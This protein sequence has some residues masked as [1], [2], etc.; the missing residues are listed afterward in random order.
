MIAI[1]SR[2]GKPVENPGVAWVPYLNAHSCVFCVVQSRYA[3]SCL[4]LAMAH[5]TEAGLLSKQTS[6]MKTCSVADGNLQA[7]N[8]QGSE[9]SYDYIYASC[10]TAHSACLYKSL[11]HKG[12]DLV[13]WTSRKLTHCPRDG[14]ALTGLAGVRADGT[15]MAALG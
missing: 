2:L 10:S 1:N 13:V 11:H 8:R 15:T 7:L 5:R 6:W 14:S 12:T 9:V 3:R 4:H